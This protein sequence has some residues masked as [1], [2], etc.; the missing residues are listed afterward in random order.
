MENFG[1]S[2][3]GQYSGRMELIF[4]VRDAEEGGFFARALGECAGGGVA[5]LRRCRGAPS[6]CPSALSQ[7]R[8]HPA[9]SG[10]KLPRAVSGDRTEFLLRW[11]RRGRCLLRRLQRF[12]KTASSEESAGN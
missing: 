10:M 12:F 11:S 3:F 9:G 1:E 2:G 4:E 6:G 5:A 8:V 7:R